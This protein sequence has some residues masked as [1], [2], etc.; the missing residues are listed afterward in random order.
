MQGGSS[1]GFRSLYLFRVRDVVFFDLPFD[2]HAEER[3]QSGYCPANNGTGDPCAGDRDRGC[4]DGTG[5]GTGTDGPHVGD[6][7]AQGLRQDVTEQGPGG[8]EIVAPAPLTRDIIQRSP[9]LLLLFILFHL[10]LEIVQ[11]L[12]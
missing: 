1:S 12:L 6:A 5:H 3:R 8:T 7:L 2:V 10:G 9:V 11:L 4:G